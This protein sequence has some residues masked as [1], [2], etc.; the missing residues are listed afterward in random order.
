MW[1]AASFG[2]YIL[3]FLNKYLPG[4]IFI[5]YYIEGICGVIGWTIGKF[6]YGKCRIKISFIVSYFVTIFGVFGI[7]LFESEIISPYAIDSEPSPYPTGSEKDRNYRLAKIV[8]YFTVVAKV[9][10]NITFSN[11]Y[12]STF[13]DRTTFP[14]LRRATAAGIC[15]FVARFLTIFAPLVAELDR[16]LPIYIVLVTQVIGLLVSFTFPSAAQ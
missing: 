1:S 15:N 8:P 7:F 2:C 11:A 16:P 4:S 10:I 14:N 6:L 3:I 12:Q 9:G 13:G 5:N